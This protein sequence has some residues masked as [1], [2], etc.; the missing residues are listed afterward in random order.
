MSE[1][2]SARLKTPCLHSLLPGESLFWGHHENRVSVLLSVEDAEKASLWRAFLLMVRRSPSQEPF[3]EHPRW[4]PRSPAGTACSA[5]ETTFTPITPV[6]T[7]LVFVYHHLSGVP[8]SGNLPTEPRQ[9]RIWGNHSGVS[10]EDTGNLPHPSLASPKP[11]Q[12]EG[13]CEIKR[14]INHSIVFQQLL[15]IS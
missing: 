6:F 14:W 11:D 7:P 5:L 2:Q 12:K 15:L 1:S 13:Q 9:G 4:E 8:G 10:G 3:R